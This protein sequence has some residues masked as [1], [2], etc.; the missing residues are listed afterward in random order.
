MEANEKEFE[1]YLYLNYKD[2]TFKIA[3]KKRKEKPTEI[4]I[5]LKFKVIIPETPQFEASATITLGETK[6]KDLMLD[7]LKD[8]KPN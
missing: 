1:G 6:V 4:P 8:D 3:K 7:A 2:G 5:H